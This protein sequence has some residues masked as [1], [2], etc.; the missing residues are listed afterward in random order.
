MGGEPTQTDTRFD[1]L[2]SGENQ[3]TTTRK[4]GVG[5]PNNYDSEDG[6]GGMVM[7]VGT[8]GVGS[9]PPNPIPGS[10]DP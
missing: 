8:V 10:K 7:V 9:S 6:S 3:I 4:M 5:K 2:I 1:T